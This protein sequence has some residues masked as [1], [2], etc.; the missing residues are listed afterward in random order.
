MEGLSSAQKGVHRWI[1]IARRRIAGRKGICERL[2]EHLFANLRCI[3]LIDRAI[4]GIAQPLAGMIRDGSHGDDLLKCL[5]RESGA[6]LN[7]QS[8]DGDGAQ[9]FSVSSEDLPDSQ[10]PLTKNSISQDITGNLQASEDAFVLQH[11]SRLQEIEIGFAAP[12][13]L[14]SLLLEQLLPFAATQWLDADVN[15]LR[16]L[17]L[18]FAA[19]GF[20][21]PVWPETQFMDPVSS[22][23]GEKTPG[24]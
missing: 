2:V 10:D 6:P 21:D 12:D 18:D 4:F 23:D 19:H 22:A 24:F 3:L 16:H 11:A 13:D 8:D 15:F 14:Q 17:R 9:V 7:S 5:Q 20:G 1:W